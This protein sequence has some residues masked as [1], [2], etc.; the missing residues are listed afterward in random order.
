MDIFD[1]IFDQ[2]VL[3]PDRADKMLFCIR[4]QLIDRLF[5]R[6]NIRRVVDTV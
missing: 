6:K 3:A 4:H 1:G 2:P 5:Q